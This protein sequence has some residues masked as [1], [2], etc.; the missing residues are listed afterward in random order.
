MISYIRIT[1]KLLGGQSIFEENTLKNFSQVLMHF[2]RL[3]K[4]T[5]EDFM[6]QSKAKQID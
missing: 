3:Y 1:L 4:Q 5:T 2:K 6:I